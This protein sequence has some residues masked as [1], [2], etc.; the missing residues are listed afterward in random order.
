VSLRADTDMAAKG[1]VPSPIRKKVLVLQP[2]YS[3]FA[4]SVCTYHEIL[5]H[6]FLADLID[7]AKF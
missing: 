1:K 3:H 4:G 6:E 2:I 7:K 5:Q